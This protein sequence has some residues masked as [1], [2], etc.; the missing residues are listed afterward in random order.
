[1]PA[2]RQHF[3][4]KNGVIAAGMGRDELAIEPTQRVLQNRRAGD[5][6]LKFDSGKTFGGGQVVGRKTPR[7]RFL[8]GLENIHRKVVAGFDEIVAVRLFVYTNQHQRRLQRNRAKRVCR[9]AVNLVAGPRRHNRDAGGELA[10]HA[11]EKIGIDGHSIKMNNQDCPTDR[12][13]ATDDEILASL[14]C[15]SSDR[16]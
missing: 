12:N 7:Q 8:R 14:N 1:M 4:D 11:A 10:Q 2:Q 15:Y 13:N 6:G 3:A 9:Q 5:F 16:F